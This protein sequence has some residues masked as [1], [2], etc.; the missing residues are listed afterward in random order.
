MLE[1]STAIIFIIMALIFTLAK[2]MLEKRWA[3]MDASGDERGLGELAFTMNCSVYDLFQ[4]AGADWRFSNEKIDRDFKN[5]VRTNQI[6]SYLH[7]Y[8]HRTDRPAEKTYQELLY[9]GGR[10]PYL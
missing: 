8:L 9:A 4:N 7:D 5:Y 3:P 1:M 10:P 6:P 2:I